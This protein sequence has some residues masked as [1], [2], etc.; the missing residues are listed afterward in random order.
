M[1]TIRCPFTGEFLEVKTVKE[2]INNKEIDY[3]YYENSR[4]NQFTTDELDEINLKEYDKRRE[5]IS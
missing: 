4:G 1:K 5:T 2:I 3:Y